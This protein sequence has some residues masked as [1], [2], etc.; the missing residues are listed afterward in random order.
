MNGLPTRAFAGMQPREFEIG[1]A[2]RYFGISQKSG[3]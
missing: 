3:I 2:Q 1:F